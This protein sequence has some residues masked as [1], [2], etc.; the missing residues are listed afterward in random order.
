MDAFSDGPTA[1]SRMDLHTNRMALSHN[2]CGCDRPTHQSPP[3]PPQAYAAQRKAQRRRWKELLA[4]EEKG[5]ARL[6]K[7]E[8]VGWAQAPAGG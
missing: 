7:E 6:G 5:R 2:T 3:R 8:A 4:A 1:S